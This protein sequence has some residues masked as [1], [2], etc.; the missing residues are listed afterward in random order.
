MIGGLLAAGF[1]LSVDGLVEGERE[2]ARAAVLVERQDRVADLS[3]P[4]LL[5]SFLPTNIFLI[6]QDQD[7][8][9][10]LRLLS[11]LF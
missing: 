1:N 9:Q 5:V 8:P 11:S 4:A 6:W 10:L 2:L 7:P 3:V